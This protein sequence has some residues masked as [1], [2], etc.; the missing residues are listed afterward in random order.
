MGYL[1]ICFIYT[2]GVPQPVVFNQVFEMQTDVSNSII[3]LKSL[4]NNT[5]CKTIKMKIQ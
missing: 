1:L 3:A 5:T 2:S 4:E